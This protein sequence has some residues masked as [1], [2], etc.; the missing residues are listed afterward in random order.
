MELGDRVSIAFETNGKACL[1]HIV[2]LPGSFVRA[3]TEREALTRIGTEIHSY[4]RWLGLKCP[5]PIRVLI[6]QWHQS[7]LKVEDADSEILLDADRRPFRSGEFEL[8]ANLVRFS[9]QTFYKAYDEAELKDYVDES[10]KR[11]TFYGPVPSTINEVFDHVLR[12]QNF[13]LAMLSIRLDVK[14]SDFTEVR[15]RC[16][17]ELLALHEK[18]IGSSIFATESELWTLK[19]V[20]RRF[21]WHDRIH[22]KA[23]ARMQAKQKRLKLIDEYDDPFRFLKESLNPPRYR[24]PKVRAKPMIE[25][26]E[27]LF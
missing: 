10:R 9:G 7:P 11:D 1:G 4:A 5:D 24:P 23:I 21:V 18:G 25:V 3:P 13:Y 22:G 19:K 6:G 2:Q 26:Q 14:G 17:D 27:G 12:T 20:L 16:V 15:S 8:L